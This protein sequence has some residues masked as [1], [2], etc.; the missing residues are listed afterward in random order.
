[1]SQ[2]KNASK[3]NNTRQ[4]TDAQKTTTQLHKAIQTY[5]QN[6]HTSGNR[7]GT[8]YRIARWLQDEGAQNIPDQ[9]RTLNQQT[10]S[11]LDDEEIT[12]LIRRFQN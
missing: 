5:M 6:N 7:N 3:K 4:P 11:P 2:Q 8:L 1:M 12:Y 9:L 10:S